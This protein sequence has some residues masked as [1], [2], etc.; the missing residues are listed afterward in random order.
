MN[1]SDKF[2]ET[3]E[4]LSP[5]DSAIASELN[6]QLNQAEAYFR[7]GNVATAIE[8]VYQVIKGYPTCATA[9]KLLG[10]LRLSQVK[11]SQAS[12]CYQTAIS[13]NPQF[14]EAL[15]NLGSVAYQQGDF[16]QAIAYYQKV[17][18]L[19]P[20]FMPGYLALGE[21]WENLEK[22]DEAI[23][24]YINVLNIHRTYA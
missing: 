2:R 22:W 17:I 5:M 18:E 6:H 1:F 12:R 14:A 23:A 7:Q 9:Y 21:L 8:S 19:N 15:A 3:S 20:K 4:I 10:N 16:H 24:A 11:I 13:I